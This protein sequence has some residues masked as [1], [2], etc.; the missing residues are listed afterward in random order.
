VSSLILSLSPQASLRKF[1]GRS[2][3]GLESQNKCMVAGSKRMGRTLL[4]WWVT[5]EMLQTVKIGNGEGEGCGICTLHRRTGEEGKNSPM[6][7]NGLIDR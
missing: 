6:E 1:G 3:G 2:P 7:V 5:K 4:P